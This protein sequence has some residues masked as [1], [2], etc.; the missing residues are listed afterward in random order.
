M[1]ASWEIGSQRP[2]PHPQPPC[3]VGS[4]CGNRISDGA[5]AGRT[6]PAVTA[7]PV[8]SEAAVPAKEDRKVFP[9]LPGSP[10]CYA[11]ISRGRAN[12]CQ[13][14]PASPLRIRSKGA[15]RLQKPDAA[16][17]F[18]VWNEGLL[19]QEVQVGQVS[20]GSVWWGEEMQ[21]KTKT[22]QARLLFENV[23]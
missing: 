10:G 11:C 2:R 12:T 18:F 3:C 4:Q 22:K 14:R 5:K 16:K 15:W 7:F 21:R 19:G 1:C 20:G 13:T 6:D 8:C 17:S 23:P 9:W